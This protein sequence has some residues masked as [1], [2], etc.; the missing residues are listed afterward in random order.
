MTTPADIIRQYA[1]A[2]ALQDTQLDRP[3]TVDALRCIADAVEHYGNAEILPY[4]VFYLRNQL[5]LCT[6]GKAQWQYNC[7]EAC[8]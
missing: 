6:R 7:G 8:R 4:D 1:G 2:C 3:L 5:H